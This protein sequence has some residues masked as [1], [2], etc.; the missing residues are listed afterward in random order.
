MDPTPALQ[1]PVGPSP[2]PRVPP[3]D[4]AVPPRTLKEVAQGFEA[5]LLSYLLKGLSQTI[6]HGDPKGTPFA[7]GF[8]DDL[9]THYLSTH[10]AKSGGIGLADV[11]LRSLPRGPGTR[12]EQ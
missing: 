3:G 5:I 12:A 9:L 6:S 4:P 11:I 1:R 8:Y 2:A 10:L 7:R